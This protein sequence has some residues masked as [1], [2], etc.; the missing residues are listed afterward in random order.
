VKW[1][2]L[3]NDEDHETYNLLHDVEI[4]EKVELMM[5]DWLK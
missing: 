4:F 2:L 5:V 3:E 1:R